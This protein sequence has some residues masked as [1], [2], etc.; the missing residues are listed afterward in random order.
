MAPLVL[1]SLSFA[2][3]V[4]ERSCKQACA[5]LVALYVASSV[6]TDPMY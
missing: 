3:G 4:R 2:L 6:E 1:A 5:W